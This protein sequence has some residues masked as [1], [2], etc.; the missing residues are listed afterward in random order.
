[1]S[2]VNVFDLDET[3][4]VIEYALEFIKEA[5]EIH[6]NELALA[7]GIKAANENKKAAA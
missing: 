3:P 1:M 6:Y 7:C 2:S 4:K 5:D